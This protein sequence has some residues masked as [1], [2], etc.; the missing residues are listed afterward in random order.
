MNII[1]MWEYIYISVLTHGGKYD[2]PHPPI[3]LPLYEGYVSVR[4][5]VTY[6]YYGNHMQ[7]GKTLHP[8]SK[9]YGGSELPNI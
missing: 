4:K 3:P 8:L 9:L 5:N 1:G 6:I 2:T 7:R